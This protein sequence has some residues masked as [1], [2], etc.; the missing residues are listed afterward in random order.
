VQAGG[1]TVFPY[2]GISI[3]PSAGSALLWNN[4]SPSGRGFKET[5]HAGCPVLLG[6]KE[7]ANHWFWTLGQQWTRP[8]GRSREE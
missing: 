1:G 4:L 8:G 6:H 5:L 3:R 7:I 2:L